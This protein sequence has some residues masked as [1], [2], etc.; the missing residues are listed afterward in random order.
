M[1]ISAHARERLAERYGI[2]LTAWDERSIILQMTG[3]DP[4]DGLRGVML[5]RIVRRADTEEWWAISVRGIAFVATYH[6]NG[7]TISTVLPQGVNGGSRCVD[8]IRA[9]PM[10]TQDQSA[11][12]RPARRG[13][14][15]LRAE[16]MAEAAE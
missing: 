13:S 8:R 10:R 12:N 5:T 9:R 7:E 6:L 4:V 1:I 16:M 2:A 15:R 14:D 11:P 3:G